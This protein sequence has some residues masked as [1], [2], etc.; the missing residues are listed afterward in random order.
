MGSYRPAPL[1]LMAVESDPASSTRERG[2]W[3]VSFPWPAGTPEGCGLNRCLGARISAERMKSVTDVALR[4]TSSGGQCRDTRKGRPG[5]PT[6]PTARTQAPRDARSGY[7][8]VPLQRWG[9]VPTPVSRRTGRRHRC[10]R[11]GSHRTAT[12]TPAPLVVPAVRPGAVMAGAVLPGDLARQAHG[13]DGELL[14]LGHAAGPPGRRAYAVLAAS[15]SSL[16]GQ[17]SG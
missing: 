6:G 12:R 9:D 14:D 5:T 15:L 7:T 16:H 10:W 11:P 17:H 1:R 4:V 13:P 2:Y 3:E 8:A